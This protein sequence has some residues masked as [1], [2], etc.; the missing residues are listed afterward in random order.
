MPRKPTNPPPAGPRLPQLLEQRSAVEAEIR[1]LQGTERSAALA[2]IKTIAAEHGISA[3]DV[4]SA[5]SDAV[6]PTRQRANGKRAGTRAKASGNHPLS[7]VK[8]PIKYRNRKTGDT[9][10]GRGLRPRWLAAELAAGRS[11]EDFAV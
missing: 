11:I 9:W 10:S 7:G 3:H 8:A 1:A 6:P 4:L 5:L 2:Q